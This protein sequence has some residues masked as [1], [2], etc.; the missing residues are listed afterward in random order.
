[1]SDTSDFESQ[2]A[3][4][5]EAASLVLRDGEE[6]ENG[7][8]LRDCSTV[9][10]AT[11]LEIFR[12][13]NLEHVA[14]LQEVISQMQETITAL[15]VR[16]SY[17]VPTRRMTQGVIETQEKTLASLEGDFEAVKLT[18]PSTSEECSNLI[19]Q[20]MRTLTASDT[21][22]GQVYLQDDQLYERTGK[23]SVDVK[24]RLEY[25]RRKRETRLSKR[26]WTER[27]KGS[28]RLQ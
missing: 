28:L 9:L 15:P 23:L 14:S 17:I 20:C 3:K 7:V 19:A 4:L 27:V 12:T 26:S 8:N 21:M 13:T 24:A 1:M 16:V 5:Q 10:T 25:L 6:S 11:Y 22:H 18:D 2:L